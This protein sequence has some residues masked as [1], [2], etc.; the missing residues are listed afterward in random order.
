MMKSWTTSI[1]IRIVSLLSLP[2]I[3]GVLRFL[4]PL[5]SISFQNSR[6]HFLQ[7]LIHLKTIASWLVMVVM[8]FTQRIPI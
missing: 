3:K 8:L 5:L 4:F 6:Q 1:L 7:L 2:S